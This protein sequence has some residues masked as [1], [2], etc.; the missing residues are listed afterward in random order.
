MPVR[1]IKI[2]YRHGGSMKKTL[3]HRLVNNIIVTQSGC[4]EWQ[5]AKNKQGYGYIFD[6]SIN[7]KVLAHRFIYS[8][9]TG[10][11]IP[12]DIDILHHCDNPPCVFP[13]HLFKGNQIINMQDMVMKG[14]EHHASGT[15]NHKAKLTEIQVLEIRAAYIPMVTT[16]S[17][18]ARKYNVTRENIHSIVTRQTWKHI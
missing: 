4:W 5:G 14:R 16:C 13:L 11:P 15:L 8:Q 2:L 17:E 9:Y 1:Y 7:K 10:Q 6:S 18:L 12:D 3:L